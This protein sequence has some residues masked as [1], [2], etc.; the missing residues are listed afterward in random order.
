M[1]VKDDQSPTKAD[2]AASDDNQIAVHEGDELETPEILLEEIEDLLAD[3][4]VSRDDPRAQRLLA[5]VRTVVA[6]QGPIPPPAVLAEYNRT[7]PGLG[8]EIVEAW[9]QQREHRIA[10]EQ[11]LFGGD[12]KRMNR[13]QICAVVIAVTSILTAGLVG[14]FGS[15][16]AAGAIVVAGVGGPA[17]AMILAQRFPSLSQSLE[18][19]EEP[20]PEK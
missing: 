19:G 17:A 20:P 16:W 3:A 10:M 15:A 2:E 8:N 11:E 4:G 6:Y 12:S 1:N 13:G 9:K 14:V 5:D 18:A 7:I